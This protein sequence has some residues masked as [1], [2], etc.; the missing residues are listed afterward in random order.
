MYSNSDI[1]DVYTDNISLAFVILISLAPELSNKNRKVDYSVDAWIG[2]AVKCVLIMS[3]GV[4][5]QCNGVCDYS[6]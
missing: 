2:L 3:A 6:T 4:L 5:E 1:K